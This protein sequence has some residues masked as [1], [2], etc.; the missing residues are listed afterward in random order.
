M[1]FPPAMLLLFGL[2][3]CFRL[4]AKIFSKKKTTAQWQPSW[5]WVKGPVAKNV[6][7]QDLLGIPGED[8]SALFAGLMYKECTQT[9]KQINTQNPP[10]IIE[11]SLSSSA[12]I[13]SLNHSRCRHCSERW[14]QQ[15]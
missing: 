5:L 6:W 13:T 10:V 9:L 2:H 7:V 12:A 15:L 3:F 4:R 14:L 1:S 8:S 11:V